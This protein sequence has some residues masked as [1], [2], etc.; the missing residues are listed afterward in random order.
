MNLSSRIRTGLDSS[1][2]G[3]SS[4]STKV[5]GKICEELLHD[6]PRERLGKFEA[7][8]LVLKS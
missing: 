6:L 2:G 7:G 4:S 3:K 5:Y 1:G 8:V